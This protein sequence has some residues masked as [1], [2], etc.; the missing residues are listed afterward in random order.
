V[1]REDECCCCCCETLVTTTTRTT[2]QCWSLATTPQQSCVL[3]ILRPHS[4]CPSKLPRLHTRRAQSTNQEGCTPTATSPT[5]RQPNQ[6]RS[7][8]PKMRAPAATR[9]TRDSPHGGRLRSLSLSPTFTDTP[10]PRTR[11][12]QNPR[13]QCRPSYD[14]RPA[15]MQEH[16]RMQCSAMQPEGRSA[17]NG[18]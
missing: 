10:K 6:Q 4:F 15:R 3:G 13:A 11:A 2:K 17:A 16:G 8:H 12:S 1:S 7:N 9:D 5:E 18:K 14:R